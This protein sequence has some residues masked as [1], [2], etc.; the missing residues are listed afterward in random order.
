[1]E[2]KSP[3]DCSLS[4]YHPLFASCFFPFFAFYILPLIIIALCYTRLC[5]YMRH[6]SKSIIQYRVSLKIIKYLNLEMF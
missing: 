2:K 6:V 3:N 4:A 5:F 1:M